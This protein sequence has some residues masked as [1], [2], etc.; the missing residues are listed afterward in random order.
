MVRLK[1]DE[2]NEALVSSDIFGNIFQLVK[3]YP[4]NNFLQLKVMNICTEIIEN[5]TNAEFRKQFFIKSGIAKACTDMAE[6]ATIKM[7]SGREIR[8]G[9]MGLVISVANKLQKKYETDAEK[10]DEEDPIVTEY[11]ESAGEEWRAFVDGELKTSNENNNKMLGKCNRAMSESENEDSSSYDVQMEKIMA[12]FSNF[13]QILSNNSGND[14][15]D[16]EDEDDY[17]KIDADP[18]SK[19]DEDLT[20]DH[21]KLDAPELQ[22]SESTPVHGDSGL[23]N[24][25]PGED[26]HSNSGL[27]VMPVTLKA[28]EVLEPEFSDNTFWEKPLGVKEDDLEAMM[29]EMSM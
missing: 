16:D 3:D 25:E 4:W 26:Y 12:R 18:T 7:E 14:D 9:Y 29:A 23:L 22:K 15:D 21:A 1:N 24:E 10:P 13:N 28:P 20:G 6:H 19:T 5:N 2:I 11:V 17:P 27:R 8:N